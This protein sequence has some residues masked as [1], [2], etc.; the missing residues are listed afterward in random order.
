MD[1]FIPAEAGKIIY[2]LVA[3]PRAYLSTL[4]YKP[5]E[6][7]ESF[8]KRLLI[9]SF[10]QAPLGLRVRKCR[11][12]ATLLRYRGSGLTKYTLFSGRS[13]MLRQLEARTHR[14]WRMSLALL[15]VFLAFR[16]ATAEDFLRGD[17]NN[18][19]VASL[20]DAY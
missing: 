3:L 1:S 20:A 19:G 17:A 13:G 5:P 12:V 2:Q 7:P 6:A 15:F 9:N 4:L 10:Q 16:S 18:D 8:W 11:R 14:I